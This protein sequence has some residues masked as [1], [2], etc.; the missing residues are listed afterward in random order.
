MNFNLFKFVLPFDRDLHQQCII[1][2]F[3]APLLGVGFEKPKFFTLHPSNSWKYFATDDETMVWLSILPSQSSLLEVPVL[4]IQQDGI[5]K[6]PADF[7]NSVLII[8]RKI[9]LALHF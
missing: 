9:Q 6:I 7:Q 5:R 2:L 1:M 8:Q 4:G 3:A